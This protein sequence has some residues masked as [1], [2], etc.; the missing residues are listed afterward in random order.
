M[1]VP[2]DNSGACASTRG[3]AMR[4]LAFI[5][6]AFELLSRFFAFHFDCDFWFPIT[7]VDNEPVCHVDFVHDLQ[8]CACFTDQKLAT[9]SASGRA[10][11]GPLG[12]LLSSRQPL[13]QLAQ[14]F[15]AEHSFQRR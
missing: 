9:L 13:R 5:P 7:H 11:L 8:Q 1:F 3:N 14:Q 4:L 12:A 2:G 15:I 6:E 10:A